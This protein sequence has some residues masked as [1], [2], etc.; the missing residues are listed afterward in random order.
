MNIQIIKTPKG[1][2]LALLPKAELD[3]L[4]EALEDKE[5]IEDIRRIEA[6]IA[7]GEDELIP[8]DIVDRLLDGEN[9][10]KVWREYRG[11]TG[12]ALADAAGM[13]AP[14]LSQIESGARE[15]SLDALKK[16]AEALKVT[17]DELV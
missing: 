13:S 17:I 6:R 7:S 8:S 3:R 5:D 4:I 11:M 9:K 15:G 12:K 16:L 14:Y 1:E 10:I 2:E